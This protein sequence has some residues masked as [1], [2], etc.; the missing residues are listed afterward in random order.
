[1]FHIVH[2]SDFHLNKQ[3]LSDWI[4]YI[5]PA[6][7]QLIQDKGLTD[8]DTIIAC[9]GDLV[10]KAGKEFTGSK[11][12]FDIFEKQVI[13]D[14]TSKLPIS[15]GHFLIIPGNHDIDRG[16]DSEFVN[17]GMNQKFQADYQNILDFVNNILDKGSEEGIQRIVPYKEFETSLYENENNANISLLGSSFI[18]ELQGQKIGVACFNS[19]W[20]AYDDHDINHLVLGE[21]Q[22]N[23]RL[24]HLKDC[25][26]RIALIHHPLDWFK[27][28]NKTTVHL[29][30]QGF[31]ALLVG[32][33]HD[34][35]TTMQIGMY[36]AM[37]VNVAPSF[38]SEIRSSGGKAFAN[39]VS[40]IHYDSAHKL[41]TS[42]YYTYNFKGRK[43]VLNTQLGDAGILSFA[44]PDQNLNNLQKV[45]NDARRTIEEDFYP[46]IDA[47]IIPNKANVVKTL[48]EAFIMPPILDGLTGEEIG[49]YVEVAD[50]IKNNQNQIFFGPAE[51]G[52][53][54][55]LYRLLQVYMED[56]YLGKIPIYIDVNESY[57]KEINTII[58]DFL[59]CSTDDA[60]L[61]V[62]H[63]VVVFLIDNIDF[64]DRNEYF[65]KRLQEFIRKNAGIQIKATAGCEL[66]G[67]T[68]S[69][70]IKNTIAFEQNHLLPFRSSHI[71]NMLNK[72]M[73]GADNIA[74]NKRLDRMVSSFC[75]Y[76]LPS[77]AMS[78]SLF[79]WCEHTDRKPINH[80]VLLDI[81]VEIILEKISSENIYRAH[82]DYKNKTMLLANIAEKMLNAGNPNYIILYS[83]YLE[84]IHDYLKKVGYEQYDANAIGAYFIERKIFTKING[85]HI[86]FSHSC[87]FHFFLAKRMIDNVEF[88]KYV[89]HEDHYFKFPRE[90]DYY[91]GLTRTD[92]EALEE[93]YGWYK[94]ASDPILSILKAV[95]IDDFFTNVI[96]KDASKKEQPIAKQIDTSKIKANRPTEE[97]LLSRYDDQ[98]ARIPDDVNITTSEH[99]SIDK[100]IVIMANILRNSEGVEDVKLKQDIYNSIIDGA[101]AWAIIF[102]EMIVRYY[103]DNKRLPPIFSDNTD[104]EWILKI[105]PLGMFTGLQK[106]IGTH[107]LTSI[108]HKKIEIDNKDKECSDIEKFFSIGL[109]WENNGP[110][111]V[112]TINKFIS[113]V[114]NNVVQ[115]YL[116]VKLVEHLYYHTSPDSREEDTFLRLLTKL[117]LKHDKLPARMTN[118]IREMYR[119][120]K[121]E[122]MRKEEILLKS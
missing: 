94:K 6:L 66:T 121:R 20:H 27:L 53:T 67:V 114:G 41:I 9:T 13:D 70:F 102:K 54:T 103:I 43:Y 29:I 46:K 7:V 57:G 72:W 3:N 118:T 34:S 74:Y 14:I 30:N 40:I 106:H 83:E 120:K 16:L 110:D 8:S 19:A 95:D 62:E 39:G 52:R 78:V 87:F 84:I 48:K 21:R 113:S 64:E 112:K 47:Q 100:V 119:D 50:I 65:I 63:E 37:Y 1:M 71:K 91:S 80:A 4:E 61:L 73:P 111:Y 22:V 98:L 107:K 92:K 81:Y 105:V 93:I 76:S 85:N 86:K 89:F 45:I 49:S 35:D 117:K 36:G 28:E 75:S 60:K 99:Y 25:Q 116:I 90:I 38:Q 26:V 12:A 69:S 108:F 51:S 32:H 31:D 23:E 33:V 77:T 44:I 2:L 55:L 10:D 82:F 96:K 104:L 122:A 115:V 109:Y 79:L 18:Y 42:E 59:K 15:K 68:P 101:I 24:S 88:R 17:I 11:E 97:K 58:K 5:S 56:S